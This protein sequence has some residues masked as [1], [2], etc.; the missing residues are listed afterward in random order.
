MW[1]G[2]AVSN[3][4]SMTQFNLQSKCETHGRVVI[5][6]CRSNSPEHTQA[7]R[8]AVGVYYL[9]KTDRDK[10]RQESNT[11]EAQNS[12]RVLW[13]VWAQIVQRTLRELSFLTIIWEC[14]K[15]VSVIGKGNYSPQQAVFSM[16]ARARLSAK[17]SANTSSQQ[18]QC[19]TEEQGTNN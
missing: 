6:P 16:G 2:V 18:R 19:F 3:V 4:G 9:E 10:R 15:V 17:C 14:G 5:L 7:I 11:G 12:Y 13:A 8:K 1:W